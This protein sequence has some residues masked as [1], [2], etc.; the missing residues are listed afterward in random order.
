MHLRE[1]FINTIDI[2][3]R[4]ILSHAIIDGAPGEGSDISTNA[5]S[6]SARVQGLPFG[7]VGSEDTDDCDTQDAAAVAQ[8]A[9]NPG[10]PL[11]RGG[12][13]QDADDRIMVRNAAIGDLA[14]MAQPVAA[15][16]A[17]PPAQ[18][19]AA[20]AAAPPAHL[21]AAAA[22]APPA[23]PVAAAAA[24]APPAQP[25]AAAA[26]AAPP[27]QPVAADDSSQQECPGCWAGLLRWLRLR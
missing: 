5:G 19:V 14:A 13:A 17:A 24:T 9:R 4:D 23:Q 3:N 11:V 27:A 7:R 20:A 15:A 12:N 10:N 16:A 1:E 22:A 26:A 18:P 6:G 25:V 8:G 21:V 2:V